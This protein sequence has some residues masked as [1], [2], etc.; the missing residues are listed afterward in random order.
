MAYEPYYKYYEDKGLNFDRGLLTSYCLS[1]R[2]KPFVILSGISGT[3]KTKIAQF[4]NYPALIASEK[5]KSSVHEYKE[6]R[7]FNSE[8]KGNWIIMTVTEGL[9]SGDGRANFKYSNLDALLNP[10][11]VALIQ[12]KID[13]LKKSGSHE[14]ICDPFEFCIE[15]EEGEEIKAMNLSN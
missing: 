8:Q 4:F 6:S 2:T 5:I 11:E 13:Y 12:S 9:I 15:T 10:D 3:G 7:E 14:N 1:L